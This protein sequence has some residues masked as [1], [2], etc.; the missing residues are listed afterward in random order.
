MFMKKKH[1]YIAV[2]VVLVV[3]V[4][5]LVFFG[6][7]LSGPEFATAYGACGGSCAAENDN[8][9]SCEASCDDDEI[10]KCVD[11][12]GRVTCSCIPCGT[13]PRP[14]FLDVGTIDCDGGFC[15]GDGCSAYC[16]EGSQARCDDTDCRC[17][18]CAKDSGSTR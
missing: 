14:K 12:G 7:K 6:D 15:E 1:S 17:I 9:D 18:S 8:G 3:A 10:P 5:A 16:G 11:E 4:V 2:A 13:M